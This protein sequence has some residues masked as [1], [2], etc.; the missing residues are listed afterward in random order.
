MEIDQ[1]DKMKKLVKNKLVWALIFVIVLAV[2]YRL[3]SFWNIETRTDQ[4]P[5]LVNPTEFK[6]PDNIR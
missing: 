2:L 5:R 4:D 3:F 6:V 1:Y